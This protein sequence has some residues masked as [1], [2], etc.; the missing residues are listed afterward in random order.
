M[1][2][3]TVNLKDQTA[4]AETYRWTLGDEFFAEVQSPDIEHGTVDVELCVKRTA[5]AYELRF[6]FSGALTVACNRCLEPMQQPIEGE[7]TLHARLGDEADDD[8]EWIT[9]AEREGTLDV[10]WNLYEMIALALPLRHVHDE[11]GCSGE[12]DQALA[13]YLPEEGGTTAERPADPRWD[14]LKK[15]LDNN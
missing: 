15:I 11:G 4:G 7:G 10:A 2:Q 3:W 6:R 9:V 12:T 13:H 1:S 14:A 5:A 8:G